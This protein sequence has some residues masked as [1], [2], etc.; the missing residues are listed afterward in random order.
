MTCEV[1]DDFGDG[2]DRNEEVVVSAIYVL[3]CEALRP[4]GKCRYAQD[5]F[6]QLPGEGEFREGARPSAQCNQ[7]VCTSDDEYV[8]G[9]TQACGQ[10]D[11]YVGVGGIEVCPRE[12]TYGL[13][14]EGVWRGFN[15]F[16][17][18]F[19]DAAFPA[20]ENDPVGLCE[21]FS[22]LKAKF[23]EVWWT[24]V[25][26]GSDDTDLRQGRVGHAMFARFSFWF[27]VC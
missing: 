23:I 16:A 12:N 26:V 8:A 21:G 22:Q 19:H 7:D 3:S 4:S 27:V 17:Y 10:N 25:G 13:S 9:D 15:T 18:G 24:E 6:S 20:T 2:L 1:V 5:G 14:G 11:V